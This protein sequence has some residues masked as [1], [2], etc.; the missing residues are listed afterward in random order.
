MPHWRRLHLNWYRLCSQAHWLLSFYSGCILYWYNATYSY[1]WEKLSLANCPLMSFHWVGKC[2]RTGLGTSA[3]ASSTPLL[4]L[5]YEQR[6]TAKQEGSLKYPS[7]TFILCFDLFLAGIVVYAE[8]L[9]VKGRGNNRWEWEQD[10]GGYLVVKGL[11]Q[12]H[13]TLW[14][15][16]RYDIHSLL[17]WQIFELSV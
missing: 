17:Y 10:Q 5:P 13:K 2:P 1:S 8:Q 6:P 16:S 15:R 12:S 11:I 4:F 3:A 14:Y 9:F 7:I